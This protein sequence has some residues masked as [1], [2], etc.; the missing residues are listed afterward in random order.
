MNILI[1]T[2]WNCCDRR[3]ERCPISA[4]CKLYATERAANERA[5]S[6][7]LDPEDPTVAV[8]MVIE[9][10]ETS[11]R[12]IAE[13][14]ERAGVSLEELE[15]A[16]PPAEGH[17]FAECGQEFA[18]AVHEATRAVA[19]IALREE[20]AI[21]SFIVGAKT[22][23]ISFDLPLTEDNPARDHAAFNLLLIDTL[24]RQTRT[25]LAMAGDKVIEEPRLRRATNELRRLLDRHLRSVHKE[26]R[27]QLEAIIQ[28][29]RAPSPF[30]VLS[31]SEATA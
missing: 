28:V 1:E 13:E 31:R 8:K 25:L 11:T 2:P 7:G 30:C 20:A 22:A 9:K 5:R 29:G 16:N 24:L 26:D 6:L 10:L 18:T 3:C 14:A 12:L 27:R 21:V 17:A 23:R 15:P 4:D 19:K